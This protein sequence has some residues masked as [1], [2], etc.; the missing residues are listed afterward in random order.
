ME[1]EGQGRPIQQCPGYTASAANSPR[2]LSGHSDPGVAIP[3]NWNLKH[4]VGWL[5]L[6]PAIL[7]GST[8]RTKSV[9]PSLHPWGSAMLATEN[10][11]WS[12]RTADFSW[13]LVPW[14]A[15]SV[16]QM[17]LLKWK[18]PGK[19]VTG[20]L[21]TC[22]KTHLQIAIIITIV[23]PKHYLQT[24]LCTLL[25]PSNPHVDTVPLLR[26]TF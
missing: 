21:R 5:H 16:W 9:G 20:K 22:Y 1:V 3:W 7:T 13:D 18:R 23:S 14:M 26:T 8:L 25:P 4:L 24:P 10:A 17:C 2:G 11:K 6:P 12:H 15:G 19:K